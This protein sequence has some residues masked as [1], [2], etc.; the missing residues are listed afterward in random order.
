MNIVFVADGN[1]FMRRIVWCDRVESE[2]IGYSKIL[3]RNKDSKLNK[4]KSFYHELQ[5][6]VINDE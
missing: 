5:L 1:K 4:I 3:I 6:V 2:I